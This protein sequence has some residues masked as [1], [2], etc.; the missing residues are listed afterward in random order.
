[1][2]EAIPMKFTE[3]RHIDVHSRYSCCPG[4]HQAE[5][6]HMPEASNKPSNK[7]SE[8]KTDRMDFRVSPEAK[9]VIRDAARIK[10]MTVAS[11]VAAAAYDAA[12][13][14]L[15]GNTLM[16]TLNT[17]ESRRL[18]ELLRN[19]PEPNALDSPALFGGCKRR[20]VA[21]TFVSRT[22]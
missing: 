15:V 1:M 21:K 12:Q 22:Q 9:Q 2:L 17:E 8:K 7:Q 4:N 16:M 10:G 5:E 14:T 13:A 6:A 19:P 20:G 3:V 11:L 18:A